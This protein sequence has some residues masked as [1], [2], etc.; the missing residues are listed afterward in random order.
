[1]AKEYE[2]KVK[3]REHV[4]N[5]GNNELY[6]EFIKKASIYFDVEFST[7]E[8]EFRYLECK[9]EFEHRLKTNNFLK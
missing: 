1:M 5:M 6:E 8:D 2:W 9:K 3:Y 4:A 7:T